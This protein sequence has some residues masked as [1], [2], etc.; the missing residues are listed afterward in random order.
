MTTNNDNIQA[1]IDEC[2][3]EQ[4]GSVSPPPTAV[5]PLHR[6]FQT[7]EDVYLTE[8]VPLDL[9]EVKALIRGWTPRTADDG[10]M[11]ATPDQIALY[12]SVT[13]KLHVV[14]RKLID[15]EVARNA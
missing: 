15:R 1:L 10:Y 7:V 5:L 3:A 13:I 12:A 4:A 14:E 2:L 8:R 11:N 9:A 6:R